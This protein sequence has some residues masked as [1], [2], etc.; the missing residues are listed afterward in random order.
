MLEQDKN[1]T[2]FPFE[3]ISLALLRGLM[4]HIITANLFIRINRHFFSFL[5]LNIVYLLMGKPVSR[6]F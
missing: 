3:T 4:I 5:Y 2:L 6:R 1:S